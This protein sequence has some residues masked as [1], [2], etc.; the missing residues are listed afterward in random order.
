MIEKFREATGELHKEIEEENLARFIMDHSI[1][2]DTYTL[3]LLQNYRAYKKTETEILKFVPEYAASK[4]LQ[5]ERDL[6]NLNVAVTETYFDFN[7]NSKAEAFGAAYVV[8]GSALGGMILAKNL[9]KCPKLEGI[10]KQ[11]FFSGEKDNLKSWKDFKE[12]LSIQNFSEVEQEQ[13]TEKAKETF[14]FFGRVF[15]DDTV[16]V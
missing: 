11:H 15:R 14:K 4:N 9:S 3:L 10:G 12:K 16:V 13:A 6:K 8:E 7:C 1:D 5:L 2:L